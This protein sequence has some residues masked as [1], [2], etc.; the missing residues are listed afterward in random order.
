M[1][2]TKVVQ[3]EAAG[4][5]VDQ[6]IA[7][8]SGWTPE[9]L[10]SKFSTK[11]IRAL[12]PETVCFVG[13]AVRDSLLGLIATDIDVA[14]S[15][16][17]ERVLDLL[18]RASIKAIPTGLEHG[19]ITAVQGDQSYEIT[20]L[21]RDVATY[22][23][24]ADVE[25]TED[26]RADAERRDF[27]INALYAAPKGQIFDPVGGLSDLTARKVRFIGDAEKR[28]NEDALRILRFYRFSARYADNIDEAGQA[29]CIKFTDLIDGL[30]VERIRDELLKI[31]ILPDILP[32]ID[33]MQQSRVMHRIFDDKWQPASFRTY[34]SNETTL[35]ATI[36]PLVRLYMVSCGSLSAK[37]VAE[38]FKLSKQERRILINVELAIQK[39]ANQNSCD[40]RRSL[41]LY[42]GD[43][44]MA[45]SVLCNTESY[46]CAQKLSR[47]WSVP[48]FPVK[49]QDLMD[50]GIKAGPAMGE[51]LGRLEGSWLDS[52]FSLSK[53]QLLEMI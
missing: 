5:P 12:G 24:H 7:P 22:G 19:T 4:P 15:H 10:T 20:T 11:I 34:C 45:A 46:K 38:K 41:Y 6:L 35:A 48:V 8:P 52:D 40:I 37:Q 51:M 39:A 18:A 43:A 2:Q 30:S 33:L 25:Y 50:M 16:P 21:R 42:G 3:A 17:P 47:E 29:A 14:T 49:G 36:N 31:F 28:I 32:T 9:W 27:T 26:W 44:T 1:S 53:S 23:R 13:G